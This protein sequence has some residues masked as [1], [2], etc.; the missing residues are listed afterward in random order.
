M[1]I[2]LL[3]MASYDR[4][5]HVNP[6]RQGSPTPGPRTGTRLWPVRN[7]AAEQVVSGRWA[8]KTSSVFTAT[9]HRSHYCPSSASCQHYGEL[10]NSFII[11]YNVIVTE[12][13]CTVNI[14]RLNHPETI[15]R[16]RPW[17]NCLPWNQSLV[18]KRLGTAAVREG[19]EASEA[20][21]LFQDLHSTRVQSAVQTDAKWA[22]PSWCAETEGRRWG[23]GKRGEEGVRDREQG[24]PGPRDIPVNW[25]LLSTLLF[26]PTWHSN[27]PS[28]PSFLFFFFFFRN[29]FCFLFLK[30]WWNIRNI[31][32]SIVIILSVQFSGIEYIY[33]VM[34]P[35]LPFTS[36]TL[37]ILQNWNFVPIKQ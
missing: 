21:F 30:L 32:F 36:R 17:K 37:S 2:N 8:S 19:R 9:H 22:P 11:Y 20:S 12:V 28:N 7:R 27:W 14:M 31:K 29:Y 13:K 23:E 35:S 24:G 5:A 34:Q 4:R 1:G 16:P 26:L 18:S 25:V 15:P 33:I 6:T 10:Y 3:G